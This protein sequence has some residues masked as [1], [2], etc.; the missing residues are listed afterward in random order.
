MVKGETAVAEVEECEALKI[1]GEGIEPR[2]AHVYRL[3]DGFSKAG[4]SGA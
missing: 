4:W 3:E 1:G 2:R